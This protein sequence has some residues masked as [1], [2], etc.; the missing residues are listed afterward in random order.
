VPVSYFI[1]GV[2]QLVGDQP[3][4]DIAGAFPDMPGPDGLNEFYI[5]GMYAEDSDYKH[6]SSF[7]ETIA[8]NGDWYLFP[9][10]VTYEFDERDLWS[11]D[12]HGDSLEF[13]SGDILLADVDG[14]GRP[15]LLTIDADTQTLTVCKWDD[16]NVPVMYYRTSQTTD[17]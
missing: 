14:C 16:D 5:R 9:V 3:F 13:D 11:F 4:E 17:N 6:D 1:D 7:G 2:Q 15:E 12:L 10:K 8:M